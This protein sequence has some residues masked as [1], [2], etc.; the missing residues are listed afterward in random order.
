MF[1]NVLH[2]S[3]RTQ[4][5]TYTYIHILH[6]DDCSTKPAVD[7]DTFSLNSIPGIEELIDQVGP[8]SWDELGADA[9]T[10][11]N[12]LCQFKFDPMV[13]RYLSCSS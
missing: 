10:A 9:E 11:R 8:D 7:H 6:A 1:Y 5:Y 3:T 12:G 13:H 2:A 4:I